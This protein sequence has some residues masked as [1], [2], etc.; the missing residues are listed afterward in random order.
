MRLTCGPTTF[1]YFAMPLSGQNV[2]HAMTV[3]YALVTDG[4]TVVD[5][6]PGSKKSHDRSG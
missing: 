1:L 2:C 4:G 6:L 5:T 3:D